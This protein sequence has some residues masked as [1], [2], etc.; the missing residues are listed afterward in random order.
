MK[1]SELRQVLKE[2]DTLTILTSE[3]GF[4]PK[5]FH[6]TE[7]GLINKKYID[8]GGTLRNDVKIGMQLW[9]ADDYEHRLTPQKFLSIIELSDSKLDLPDEEIEIEYQGDTIRKY[10][11]DFDGHYFHLRTTLTDFL[12]PDKCGVPSEKKKVSLRDL[13]EKSSNTS[14]TPGSGCC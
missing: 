14:C 1:L 2:I 10:K 8:C 13:S 12:A 3:G 7:V 5:H 6:V 4:V 9:E 11:L